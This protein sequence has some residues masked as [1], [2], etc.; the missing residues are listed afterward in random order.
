MS[1]AELEEKSAQVAG[2]LAAAGLSPGDR[3]P[4]SVWD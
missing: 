4:G 1:A 3:L 2:Q